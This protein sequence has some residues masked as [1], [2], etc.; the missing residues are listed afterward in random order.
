[1]KSNPIIKEMKDKFEPEL[2][3]KGVYK[4]TPEMRKNPLSKK[5]SNNVVKVVYEGY[6]TLFDNVHHT[7]AFVSKI[8]EGNSIDD[9]LEIWVNTTKV[10]W[11][12]DSQTTPEDN[13]LPF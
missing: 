6:E 13:D 7:N 1:M 12:K 8:K 2:K 4:P 3:P 9:I 11:K 10:Y 5:P